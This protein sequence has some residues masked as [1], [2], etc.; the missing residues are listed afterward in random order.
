MP[1]GREMDSLVAEKV[2]GFKWDDRVCRICGWPLKATAEEGCV[3]DNCRQRPA[4]QRR[5]DEPAPYSI[6]IAAAWDVIQH[7]GKASVDMA[8][9]G[10][11]GK[12]G[13]SFRFSEPLSG[14]RSIEKHAYAEGATAPL[15]I[16]RAALKC[17]GIEEV[18]S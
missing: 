16:C 17:V 2:M 5:A 18:P 7:W 4:P 14:N 15:A 13:C 12:W 10:Y 1:A 6:E 3:V 11:D 9:Y 8:R